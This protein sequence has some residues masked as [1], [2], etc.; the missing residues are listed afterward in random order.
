MASPKDTE[1][2]A[3]SSEGVDSTF[4]LEERAAQDQLAQALEEATI[5]ANDAVVA[6]EQAVTDAEAVQEK[7]SQYS[8]FVDPAVL[9]KAQQTVA[10][11]ETA[12][13]DAVSAQQNV[14]EATIA[15]DTVVA[16]AEEAG[17]AEAT[18]SSAEADV[19]NGGFGDEELFGGVGEN[20]FVFHAHDG[21]DV[22]KDFG[23]G[24]K[25]LFE[26][27]EF[28]IDD[29]DVQKDGDDSIITFGGSNNISVR[30]KHVDADK[31]RNE[32]DGYSISEN[33]DGTVAITFDTKSQ[34]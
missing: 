4:N 34:C 11:A 32:A 28:Q 31:L 30:F 19:L 33:S 8:E 16:A 24:D 23:I 12:L 9:E 3:V 20:I 25:V 21:E 15:F 5:A 7:I 13:A 10:L 18:D 22:I 14:V 17:T 6:A 26:W 27:S 1:V 2:N 29:L